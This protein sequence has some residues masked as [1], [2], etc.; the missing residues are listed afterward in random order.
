MSTLKSSAE[1][2]TINADG[3]SSDIKFQINAVEKASIDSSGAFTS[4][5]I[6]A[7]AL[8]GNLPAIDGSNLTGIS[9]GTTLTGSTNNTIPTVT[10]ANAISGEA[11]L[12]FDGTDLTLGTGNLIIG[13]AGKGI[14]FSAQTGEA[15]DDAE[16]DSE[17]LSHYE[18]G[19]WTPTFNPVG[20]GTTWDYEQQH[21]YYIRIGHFVFITFYVI[22]TDAYSP[23]LWSLQL[24]QL[25]FNPGRPFMDWFTT[26]G[27]G[28][29]VLETNFDIDGYTSTFSQVDAVYN[30]LNLCK[31]KDN[32]ATAGMFINGVED[33]DFFKG[34]CIYT[35]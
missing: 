30:N 29:G 20:A 15:S 25:P 35:I 5:T 24:Y 23:S 27:P 26:T 14:D 12:T 7:T 9:A 19:E 34:N 8:T 2:L 4:T 17:L 1:D 33:G 21:G 31:G 3:G 18:M 28:W 16:M 6:D 13:T 22:M 10:G 11:N 32:T